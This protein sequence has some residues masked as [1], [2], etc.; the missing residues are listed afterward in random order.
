M[1]YNGLDIPNSWC[2]DDPNKEDT[3]P[4]ERVRCLEDEDVLEEE[5]VQL[6]QLE[7][8]SILD[9]EDFKV[10]LILFALCKQQN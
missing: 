10:L 9:K 5:R 8:W 6:C 7:K 4:A 2:S 3:T 1:W